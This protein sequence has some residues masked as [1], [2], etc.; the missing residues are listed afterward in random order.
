VFATRGKYPNRVIDEREG[1][2]ALQS[3]TRS[4][5]CRSPQSQ[6][7]GHPGPLG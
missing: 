3:E 5:S 4:R 1:R 2:A 7:A 6:P